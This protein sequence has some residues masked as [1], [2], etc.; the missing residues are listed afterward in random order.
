MRKALWYILN[1]METLGKI[2][3]SQIRVKIMRLFLFQQEQ[4]FDIDDVVKR[5]KVK[6]DLARKELALLVKAGFLKKKVFTKSIP[7][8]Q[9]KTAK[10]QGK[11]VEFKKLKKQGWTINTKY[12]LIKPL[13]TLLIESELIKEKEISSKIRKTG[14]IKLIVLS[15]IFIHDHNRKIDLLVVG[16]KLKRDV[17][18]KE[19]ARIESEIGKELSY[20]VFD[21]AEFLYRVSMYDKLIRDVLENHHKKIY[22][23]II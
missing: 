7:K 5:S 16:N 21:E 2:F 6:K 19:I 20:A 4:A 12:E 10:K 9:S 1:A 17:L 18:R 23:K 8:K 14:T 13:Q 11:P 22:N 3:G 15:G